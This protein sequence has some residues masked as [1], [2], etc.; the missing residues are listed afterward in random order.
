MHGELKS[1][2][3]R[4]LDGRLPSERQREVL[5]HL[6]SRPRETSYGSVTEVAQSVGRAPSTITRTAQMLGYGGWA[7]F[8]Q[9]FRG[10]YL[11]ALSA[12]EVANVHEE[13]GG[14]PAARSMNLD[15]QALNATVADV[16]V[17]SIAR[18]AALVAGSRRTW[19]VGAG[20]YAAPARALGH[21][22]LLAGYDV[23]M[24]EAD[25]AVLAN[26]L[27][28]MTNEDVVIAFGVWRQYSST[29]DFASSAVQMGCPLVLITDDASMA[30]SSDADVVL[31][32]QS[33][34][35]SFFPSLIAALAVSQAI[36]A[37]LAAADPNR[38]KRSVAHA[39]RVW[40]RLGVMQRRRVNGGR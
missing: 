29:L 36:M 3:D 1:W 20:S 12:V 30:L 26:S 16:D 17:T 8:Q 27:A 14:T 32:V 23:R 4:R 35:A 11:A 13:Q 31:T 34:G 15:Q 19:L 18:T 21:N 2:I 24:L 38:T 22:A 33:E 40:D 25:A 9:D 6:L 7:D 5:A 10:R 39:E 37:E 28:R